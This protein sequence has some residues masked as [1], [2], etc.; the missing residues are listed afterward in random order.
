MAQI[1][2]QVTDIGLKIIAT[3][4]TVMAICIIGRLRAVEKI[5]A[6]QV[7][8]CLQMG[9]GQHWKIMSAAKANMYV[10]PQ[11]HILQWH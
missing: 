11:A 1:Q 6:L 7:G 2:Q 8:M 4:V 10:E 3:I 9:N 5:Y